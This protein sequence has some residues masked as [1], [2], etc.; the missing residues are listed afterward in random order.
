MAHKLA[1]ARLGPL[2]Y[3]LRLNDLIALLLVLGAL[4]LDALDRNGTRWNHFAMLF[5]SRVV[6]LRLNWLRLLVG[7][8]VLLFP[9]VARMALRNGD[10]HWRLLVATALYN[11]AV[12]MARSW[13]LNHL[14]VAHLLLF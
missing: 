11:F 3:G 8:T 10:S 12:A 7:A 6:T 4:T 13:V 5:D 9:D 14:L 2:A 1:G